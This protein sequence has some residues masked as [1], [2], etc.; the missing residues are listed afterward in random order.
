MWGFRYTLYIRYTRYIR[1]DNPGGIYIPWALG[2]PASVPH[3]TWKWN[4][5]IKISDTAHTALF[6][7]FKLKVLQKTSKGGPTSMQ[8]SQRHYSGNSHWRLRICDLNC[9]VP[10]S[11]NS[12]NCYKKTAVWLNNWRP[13]ST[14]IRTHTTIMLPFN[15]CRGHSILVTQHGCSQ[16]PLS[17]FSW[18][19]L[20][21]QSI[22]VA[23]LETRMFWHVSHLTPSSSFSLLPAYFFH[24]T[25]QLKHQF[26]LVIYLLHSSFLL[27]F[28]PPSFLLFPSTSF[29]NYISNKALRPSH[30][31]HSDFNRHDAGLHHRLLNHIPVVSIRLQSSLL[32]CSVERQDQWSVW[33]RWQT[34]AERHD[35]DDITRPRTHNPRGNLL[36]ISTNLRN[37][38]R[39]AH[40][41]QFRWSNEISQHD[42]VHHVLAFDGVLSYRAQ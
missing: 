23:W 34:L 12:T 27:L 5:K 29:L 35:D 37:Y 20:D 31:S 15:T 32:S 36:R 33:Q 41:R 22:T 6:R 38:H 9:S 3:E 11:S 10:H 25:P 26:M 14:T 4:F 28:P 21:W 30:S 1:P 2:C 8:L 24:L 7:F 13:W 19:C 18:Q 42:C 40:L 17:F 39:G 16:P